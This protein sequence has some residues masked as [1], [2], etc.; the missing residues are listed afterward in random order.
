MTRRSYKTMTQ[1]RTKGPLLFTAS[2]LLYLLELSE[3]IKICPSLITTNHL[4]LITKESLAYPANIVSTM[5]SNWSISWRSPGGSS[6]AGLLLFPPSSQVPSTSSIC[7]INWLLGQLIKMMHHLYLAA[8][9]RRNKNCT[10]L[11]LISLS[12]WIMFSNIHT[13]LLLTFR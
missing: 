9:Q 10:V 6:G 1:S 4:V 7:R 11:L 13:A 3:V 12:S 2:N 5:F 8:L